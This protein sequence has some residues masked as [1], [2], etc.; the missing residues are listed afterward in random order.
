MI[1][2]LEILADQI[3]T[4]REFGRLAG[5]PDVEFQI[6]QLTIALT[7]F[8]DEMAERKGMLTGEMPWVKSFRS[9]PT[10]L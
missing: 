9:P 4:L 8:L 3:A 7:D 5:D 6:D 2:M 10:N 1:G